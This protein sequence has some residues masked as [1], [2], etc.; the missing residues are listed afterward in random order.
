[1]K[2][3]TIVLVYLQYTYVLL[4]TKFADD[5]WMY[6]NGF[7]EPEGPLPEWWEL[8]LSSLPRRQPITITSLTTCAQAVDTMKQEGLNFIPVLDGER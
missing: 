3:Q 8:P 6:Q 7:M 5:K 2:T 4:R 1:M